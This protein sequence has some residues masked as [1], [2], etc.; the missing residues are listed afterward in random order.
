M[1]YENFHVLSALLPRRLREPFEVLY[2]W[3]RYADDCAD[4]S[5]SVDE[6]VDRLTHLRAELDT[7]F[8]QAARRS[9]CDSAAEGASCKLLNLIVQY[10][11]PREPFDD[12]LDAF[13]QD[14]RVCRYET[15]S[16]LLDYC[17]R[18]ANPVGRLVLKLV[19]QGELK[20]DQLDAS[21]AICTA[22]QLANFWQ[23]VKR[24][25]DKGRDYIP[26]EMA[27]G[28]TFKETLQ[29]LVGQTELLFER[30]DVLPETLPRDV[31]PVIRLFI[32][33]GRTVLK[34]I[35]RMGYCTDCRRPVVGRW[36]KIRILAWTWLET[37]FR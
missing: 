25:R 33:G 10:N 37:W 36:D 6:A 15:M 12:L 7:V 1:H 20:A 2:S 14:Q 3:C 34:K 35:K 26:R 19:C 28:R 21:D 27:Q 24:D 17:R 8:D 16:E 9:K 23:D 13:F 18:S 31:R 32:R 4:E 29:V 11:L 5:A 22:L 30:G